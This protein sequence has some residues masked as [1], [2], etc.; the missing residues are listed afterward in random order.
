MK[1]KNLSIELLKFLAVVLVINSHMDDLYVKYNVLATGGAIGDV[2]FFFTSGFTLFLGRFGRFDNWY[3]RRIKRIYPSV[4]AWAAIL[5]FF[6][7]KQLSV[8]QIVVGGGFWFISCIMLYY[9]VL[10]FVRKYASN[11]P[12]IPFVLCGTFVLVWYFFED[13]STLF[14][15]NDTYFKWIHYFLFVLAGAYVGN[16]TVKL[17]CR[18]IRDCQLLVLSLVL[19]YGIQILA[20][21]NAMVMQFQIVTLIPLMGIVI[22]TYKLCCIKSLKNIMKTRFGM[23]LR[24]IAGL[25]LEAYIVQ[26]IIIQ[27]M[28]EIMMTIFPINL[29]V[30]FVLIIVVAYVTR[31]LGRFVS[32]LFE[33]EDFDW[34]AMIKPID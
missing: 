26:M 34:I 30:T 8:K 1:E 20:K 12:L 14:M 17:S 16:N 23:C 15:Y 10:Y 27:Y 11:K 4:I 6:G 2:L 5:S 13:R 22:Y 25:C 33:K 28:S 21:R 18:P 29:V 9:V 24:F 3:K 32:Q 7:I 19:F 31:C